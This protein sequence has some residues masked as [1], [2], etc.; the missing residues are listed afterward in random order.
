MV[1][2][3]VGVY[4]LTDEHTVAQRISPRARSQPATKWLRGDLNTG[5]CDSKPM[6]SALYSFM[7]SLI[8]S[9]VDLGC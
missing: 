1:P 9:K 6:P 5:P 7:V 4:S 8:P 2:E 3:E